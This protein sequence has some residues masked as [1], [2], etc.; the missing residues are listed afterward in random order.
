MCNLSLGYKPSQSWTP[1]RNVYAQVAFYS[2]T[3]RSSVW[4]AIKYIYLHSRKLS[5][6]FPH[7]TG[8]GLSE[9]HYPADWIKNV[10]VKHSLRFQIPFG[11]SDHAGS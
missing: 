7:Q 2:N 8:Q 10:A 4:H 1:W 11:H 3:A 5:Q 6:P 9:H